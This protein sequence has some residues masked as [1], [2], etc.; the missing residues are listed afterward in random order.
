MPDVIPAH[1]AVFCHIERLEAFDAPPKIAFGLNII[2][3][4]WRGSAPGA[5]KK[6]PVTDWRLFLPWYWQLENL[7]C[8]VVG[9][10]NATLLTSIVEP[11]IFPMP[12]AWSDFQASE[13]LD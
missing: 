5:D 12:N 13:L 6:V 10:V 2:A 8:R 7:A 4:A 1:I 3:A 11:E 9:V